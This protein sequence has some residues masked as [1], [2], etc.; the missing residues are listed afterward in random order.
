MPRIFISYRREDSSDSAGR[1]YDWLVRHFGSDAVF[2]DVDIPFGVDFREYLSEAVGRCDVLLAIIGPNWLDI[3][4]TEGSHQGERRLDDPADFVR[5]EIEAALARD[6]PVIPVLVGRATMPREPS[7]PE[8]LKKLA[9][10]QAAEA[11]SGRDFDDQVNRLIRGIERRSQAAASPARVGDVRTIR[12]TPSLEIPFA[13]IGC[14]TFRMG[15]PESEDGRWKDEVLHTVTLTQPYHLGVYP[16]TVSEFQHFVTAT[17]YSTEAEGDRGAYYW[18]GSDW[19]QNVRINWGNPGF[20]QTGRHPVVCVSWNDAQKMI[21]WLN[22]VGANSGWIFSLPTE[23][24]WEYACRA[25]SETA[26]WWGND[27]D[28]LGEYAWFTDNSG[29]KTHAVQSKTPNPWGLFHMHGHVWE[30]CADWFGDYP[31]GAVKDP[32]G[33]AGDGYRV[34][35]GG[36]WGSASTVCRSAIRG[37]YDPGCRYALYGFRLAASVRSLRQGSP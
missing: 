2:L 9:F 7:L 21:G 35:R 36:G 37:S 28:Q 10:R 20:T 5:I 17:R 34:A 30:W 33:A 12:I 29:G 18:T 27:A 19:K 25:G 6:I 3:R 24:Q 8:C 14:G 16:V 22:H 4:T 1:I 26:F 11:R 32:S 31:V 15:S 23:A 13:F